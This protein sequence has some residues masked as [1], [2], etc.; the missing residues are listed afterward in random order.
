[1][2]SIPGGCRGSGGEIIV[3]LVPTSDQVKLKKIILLFLFFT[4]EYLPTKPKIIS[5]FMLVFMF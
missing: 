5:D 4:Y 2:L 3:K 1:V